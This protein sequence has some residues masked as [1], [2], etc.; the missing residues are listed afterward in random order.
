MTFTKCGFVKVLLYHERVGFVID[1]RSAVI[2]EV[3]VG[4]VGTASTSSLVRVL[5]GRIKTLLSLQVVVIVLSYLFE[6]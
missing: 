5:L 2:I 4:V 3:S 1:C 6:L